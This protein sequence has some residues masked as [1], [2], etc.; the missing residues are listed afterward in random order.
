MVSLNTQVALPR[1]KFVCDSHNVCVQIFDCKGQFLS[2]FS[3]KDAAS[4]LNFLMALLL[5]P[6]N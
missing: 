3:K 4:K 6:I 5:M 1:M 2:S